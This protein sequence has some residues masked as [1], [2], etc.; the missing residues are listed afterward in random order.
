MRQSRSG[1][2]TIEAVLILAIFVSLITAGTRALRNNDVLTSLVE[3][4]W[5]HVAGM[6]ENGVWGPP[7]QGRGLH[8]NHIT[9]HGSPQGDSP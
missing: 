1:Q 9:R 8:P 6:I 7:E 4:P 2:I 3:S 5:Q